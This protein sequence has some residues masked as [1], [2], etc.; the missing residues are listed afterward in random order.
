MKN[1][2]F[3]LVFAFALSTLWA[4]EAEWTER[5]ELPGPARHH[6]V[7]WSI[8]GYGYVLTGS[9]PNNAPL[10]DMYKYD[11]ENDEWE[12]LPDFAGPARSFSIGATYEGEGYLGFGVGATRYLNDLWKYNPETDTWT[13]LASCP[14]RPR[15]HPAFSIAD[16]KIF[17]GM[18]N[19]NV[20]GNFNDYWAYDIEE[21]E[22]EQIDNLPGVPR[23]HPFHFV[24]DD[25]VFAGFGH[26]AGIYNDWYK[27]DPQDEEWERMGDL[28]GEERVAG[29]QFSWGGKGYVLSGDGRTHENLEEGEFWEYEPETDSWTQ[30]PSHPGMGR[31]APGSFVIDGT[32]YFL[33]GQVRSIGLFND[34][35]SYE[36]ES[37]TSVENQKVETLK[38][39]PN[40]TQQEV[41]F[42]VP[43]ANLSGSLLTVYSSTGK[44]LYTERNAE[45]RLDMEAFANG[46]YL[47]KLQTADGQVYQAKVLKQ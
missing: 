29:T 26:G 17:V 32:V 36:L 2:T 28:P 23:H 40:P 22:W 37:P 30:L 14:C 33:A 41:S 47:L 5:E 24:I 18:G 9:A 11:P 1:S 13:E 4:Q 39:Y 3:L 44:R 15:A 19:N 7:T 12:Q 25:I 16:G 42:E 38:V 21:D 10:S 6:P 20:D 8:D 31:W 34:L 46:L 27:Y 43:T 35:W 45:G